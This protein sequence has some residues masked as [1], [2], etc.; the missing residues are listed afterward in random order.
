[1]KRFLYLLILISVFVLLSFCLFP[2]KLF[3]YADTNN[4]TVVE[5]IPVPTLEL[6][7]GEKVLAA[8]T[9]LEVT[10]LIKPVDLGFEVVEKIPAPLEFTVTPILGDPISLPIISNPTPLPQ[11]PILTDPVPVEPV[12]TDPVSI[13]QTPILINP[14]P[15]ELIPSTSE[16]PKTH[17][18]IEELIA[19]AKADLA[20]R[21]AIKIE[22]ISTQSIVAKDWP[23]ASLGCPKEGRLYAQ[24]ITPG[25][26]IILRARGETY[27]YRASFNWI[28]FCSLLNEEQLSDNSNSDWLQ[29]ETPVTTEVETEPNHDRNENNSEISSTIAMYIK[30]LKDT[31]F[32]I[33]KRLRVDLAK[34][35]PFHF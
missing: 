31:S 26:L 12:L 14:T 17:K 23:D 3:V 7:A 33:L 9:N 21:L 8:E 30:D 20:Q 5:K 15:I 19:L 11:Y 18:S 27:D 16:E 35:F 13:D 34:F 1:M 22:E 2:P 10:D 29:I 28:T 25:H 6:Q 24:V 32:S 4:F